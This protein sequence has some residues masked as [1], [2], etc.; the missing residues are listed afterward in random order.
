[1]LVVLIY[2]VHFFALRV[3]TTIPLDKV[4]DCVCSK[5]MDL[6]PYIVDLLY[7]HDGKRMI[8]LLVIICKLPYA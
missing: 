2:K 8:F 4:F 6:T 7:V 5:W 1:M 3:T